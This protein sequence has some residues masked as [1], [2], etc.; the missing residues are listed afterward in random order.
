MKRWGSIEFLGVILLSLALL[1]L[2]TQAS[3]AK[4]PEKPINVIMCWP[5]GGTMDISFRPLAEAAS[6]SIGQPILIEYRAGA[7][8]SVG[9]GLLKT[10]KPDGYTIGSTTEGSVTQQHVSKVG[11][12]IT[13][14][15]TCIMQYVDVACG[16]VVRADSP[17]K[18]FKELVDYAK[19]NPG[20]VRY[21][22]ASPAGSPAL[23]MAALSKQFG[24]DWSLIPFAGGAPAVTALLGGHVEAYSATLG[25]PKP[26]ILSGR[27]RLLAAFGEKRAP[28]FP[29]IPT[30][31]ELGFPVNFPVSYFIFGP[32]GL[33]AEILESL[34]QAF[35]KGLQDPEFIKACERGESI[36]FYRSPKETAE[37][38]FKLNENIKQILRELKMSKE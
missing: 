1:S 14:D 31:N 35:K 25:G 32:K 21:S 26:H 19:A 5:P 15:F 22:S 27:L 28:S 37:H 29:D 34:H 10:K 12:D 2:G 13:K 9:M 16:L 30:I 3:W 8:G 20:K 38:I 23:T 36:I 24:I 11:Y 6:K 17:W 4:Y 18:T 7:S 33:S